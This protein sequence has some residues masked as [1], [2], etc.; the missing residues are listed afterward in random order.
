MKRKRGRWIAAALALLMLAG[1]GENAAQSGD[2]VYV[3]SVGRLAGINGFAGVQNRFSGMIEPQ[4]TL[5]INP[6]QGRTVKT[7]FVE[8]GQ[9][10][11][12][13]DALFVYDTDDIELS[14]E[15]AQLEIEKLN[16][17]IDTYYSEIATLQAEKEKASE[18]NQLEYTVEIQSRYQSIKQAEYDKKVKQSEIDK[19]NSQRENTTVYS[20]IDGVVQSMDETVLD[21]NTG[22]VYGQQKTFITLMAMGEYRVKA[23]INEQNIR[24]ISVGDRVLIRSRVDENETWTGTIQEIDTAPEEDNNM[25]GMYYASQDSSVTSSKYPFYV[26]LD[27][28]ENLILGQHVFVELIS[29]SQ[30]EDGTQILALPSAYIV[31]NEGSPYVWAEE[32]G[33]ITKRIV[34][35]GTYYEVEDTYEILDGLNAEDYIAFP[36]EGMKEGR[37]A[38]RNKSTDIAQE[39][40]LGDMVQ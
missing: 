14:I 2:A 9:T 8:E 38:T 37:A 29:A 28:Y 36:Q 16:N 6:D 11:K 40:G 27:S 20:E 19:L 17:S 13:G 31:Q 35:L 25:S 33:K 30:R 22:D 3:D 12:Q 18:D 4:K 24:E 39:P 15:Q 23:K 26:V 1:C 21:G 7:V 10:V 34:T 5:K 32:N